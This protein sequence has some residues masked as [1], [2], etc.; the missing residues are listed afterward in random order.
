MPWQ[1]LGAVPPR[2]LVPARLV[3]H[4]AAQLVAAASAALLPPRADDSHTSLTWD[5]TRRAFKGQPIGERTVA[6]WIVDLVLSVD[7]RELRLGGVT[8]GDALAWLGATL[9]HGGAI[10]PY[11]HLP[12]A[13]PVGGDAPFPAADAGHTELARWYGNAALLLAPIA[14]RAEASPLR[15]WP[16]H[17]DIATLLDFG[18]GRT[19]G[20]GLSPGDASYPEPYFYVTPWS[21]PPNPDDRPEKGSAPSLAA[22]HW[23]TEG[24]FGAVLLGSEV[25]G[26][27]LAAAF[28]DQAIAACEH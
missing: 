26:R 7:G 21:H 25:S 20:V 24:W 19:L 12:P 2:E 22:G 8:R 5:D 16:H 28:V 1:P 14:A 17:L 10:P 27:D 3:L 15:V 9:G 23:H 6:L 11:P 13:H 18:G 4:W